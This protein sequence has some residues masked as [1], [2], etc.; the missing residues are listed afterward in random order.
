MDHIKATLP[1][2]TGFQKSFQNL[3]QD[4]QTSKKSFDAIAAQHKGKAGQPS[5]MELPQVFELSNQ[6]NAEI[7]KLET[8]VE[9]LILSLCE[10]LSAGGVVEIGLDDTQEVAQ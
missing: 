10:Q 1:D 5:D 7:T 6:Y 9:P 2:A 3:V 8:V 4:L